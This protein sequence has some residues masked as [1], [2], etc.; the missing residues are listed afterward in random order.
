MQRHRAA[1]VSQSKWSYLDIPSVAPKW[2][3]RI[4]Q[5]LGQRCEPDLGKDS[6]VEEPLCRI[7]SPL[8]ILE[9]KEHPEGEQFVLLPGSAEALGEPA[10]SVIIE[11]A[12][13]LVEKRFLWL[14]TSIE[15]KKKRVL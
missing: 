8:V 7:V 12:F 15:F 14:A 11:I 6:S 13:C 10:R 2:A 1:G 5:K 3:K 9:H 4:V